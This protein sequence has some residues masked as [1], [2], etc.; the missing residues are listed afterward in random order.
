MGEK[1][2]RMA[3]PTA[4]GAQVSDARLQA[5]A[6]KQHLQQGLQAHQRGQTPM[7][8]W[9]YQQGLQIFAGQEVEPLGRAVQAGLQH[10]QGLL[11]C[12]AGQIQPGLALL[13][14]A[15]A[16]NFLP[17]EQAAQYH[18]NLAQALQEHAASLPPECAQEALH[19]LQQAAQLAPQDQEYALQAARALWQDGQ[20]APALD[21]LQALYQRCGQQTRLALL[22]QFAQYLYQSEQLPLAQQIFQLALEKQP[23][24]SRQRQIGF[25]LPGTA[26]AHW[27]EWTCAQ[28]RPQAGAFADQ[29][30]FASW[31]QA[32]DLHVIDQFLPEP[33][34]HRQHILQ[35]D[36]HALRYHGQNYPGRQTDGLPCAEIM[37]ALATILNCPLKFISPDNGSARLSF[38]D[39][40]A[41]SDIHVDNESGDSRRL[42][43]AVLY[44]NLP[45]QCRGGTSFWRHTPTGF[46]CRPQQAALQAAGF[47]NF[48]QFQE[49]HL[50]LNQSAAA[51]NTLTTRR[52]EWE[53]LFTV[54]MRF[55]R[56]LLYRGDYFHAIGEVFGQ[57]A[58]D[59]RLTQL[60]FFETVPGGFAG[61][62]QGQQK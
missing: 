46:D 53:C 32:L 55:N 7:A 35:Q 27:Q 47:A 12:Q 41:K 58:Q 10:Y 45:E 22:D 54:P 19:H 44:L 25:A 8:L 40:V 43:A 15:L 34:Q 51:F 14:A 17:P 29:A 33:E 6:A 2:R 13:R 30:A 37:R 18:F 21:M 9:H 56:L 36:F 23:A 16:E 49:R 42:Y 31:W 4:P 28:A 62:E 57:D 38:A 60:F 61:T 48:R 1:K 26:L 24:L 11:F 52:N 20:R 59:A 5:A 39:S 50:P 3:I